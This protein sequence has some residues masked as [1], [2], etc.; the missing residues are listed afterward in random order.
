MYLLN[1][2][3]ILEADCSEQFADFGTRSCKDEI[4]HLKKILYSIVMDP[5][6]TAFSLKVVLKVIKW[7]WS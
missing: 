5:M 2:V 6:L 1:K 4:Q 3:E 7:L